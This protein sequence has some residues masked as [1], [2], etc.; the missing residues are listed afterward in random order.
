MHPTSFVRWIFRFPV[1]HEN[2]KLRNKA[3]VVGHAARFPSWTF[4]RKKKEKAS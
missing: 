4:A 3:Q 1:Y 2:G